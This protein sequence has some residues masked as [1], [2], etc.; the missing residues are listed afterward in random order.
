M[1][2]SNKTL[3]D[4]YFNR[5]YSGAHRTK[6]ITVLEHDGYHM[7]TGYGLSVYAIDHDTFGHIVFGG[8]A[9][10][11]ARKEAGTVTTKSN[12]FPYI[13]E[14]GDILIAYADCE[15]QR[16]CEIKEM[17]DIISSDSIVTAPF[18]N[19]INEALSLLEPLIED[20]VIQ[21]I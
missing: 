5:D 4:S 17:A 8:W 19:E 20:S 18:Y 15:T 21:T 1:T 10:S 13:Y 11:Q 2:V 7:L 12:H 9:N 14:K 16:E 3:I 6:S